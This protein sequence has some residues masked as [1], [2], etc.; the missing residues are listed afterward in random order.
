MPLGENIAIPEVTCRL[1]Q[2]LDPFRVM[3]LSLVALVTA[4][5]PL[6]VWGS[7]RRNHHSYPRTLM[8]VVQKR[9]IKFCQSTVDIDTAATV[10][11]VMP[12]CTAFQR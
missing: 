10:M 8:G 12:L 11:A 5:K 1:L 6:G 3:L 4:A 7:K 9:M 2:T